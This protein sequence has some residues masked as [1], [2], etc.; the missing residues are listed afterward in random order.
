MGSGRAGGP[1]GPFH[2][3]LDPRLER[4]GGEAPAAGVAVLTGDPWNE[5]RRGAFDSAFGPP[6]RPVS[7][8]GTVL[9]C[10]RFGQLTRRPDHRNNPPV[11]VTT[12]Q[13][14]RG[15]TESASNSKA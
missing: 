7:K 13:A 15:L 2:L 5:P 1:I 10:L 11:A 3:R 8:A 6:G 14:A 4:Q 12:N 9:D